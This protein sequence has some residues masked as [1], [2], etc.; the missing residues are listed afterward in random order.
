MSEPADVAQPQQPKKTGGVKELVENMLIAFVLAFMFRCFVVE[1][2]VIPTGSM[3][4]TLLGAHM[5]HTDP[6]SG[7]TWITNYSAVEGPGGQ[8]IVPPRAVV[9]GQR[10]NGEPQ[11][12]PLISPNTLYRVPPVI[13]GDP[14]NDATAPPIH[15][16]DRILVQ[17]YIY[18]LR[19]PA[20]WDVIV[21]KNPDRGDGRTEPYQQ[22]FIKRLIGLPGETVMILDGDIYVADTPNPTPADYVIQT[23]PKKVQDALWRIVYDHDFKSQGLPRNVLLPNGQSI[24]LADPPFVTPWMDLSG[25]WDT[26]AGSDGRSIVFN[27]TDET[28]GRATLRFDADRN[29]ILDA[30]LAGD[31]RPLGVRLLAPMFTD[32]LAADA[33]LNSHPT[34]DKQA[35]R[36]AS[37]PYTHTDGYRPTDTDVLATGGKVVRGRVST[38]GDA[39]LSVRDV[40]LEFD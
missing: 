7:Y 9:V 37:Y 25:T 20:R 27:G 8:M 33:T 38:Q 16:G 24:G 32:W 39:M 14:D 15:Y 1:A 5:R 13:E 11:V 3:A 2:F 21:F 6:D 12:L 22:N 35:R 31:A 17:K 40:M 36:S 29:K 19:D 10:K 34:A 23:K 26:D 18:L 4:P 30:E 28:V